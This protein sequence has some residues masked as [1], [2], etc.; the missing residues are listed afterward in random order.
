MSKIC[1]EKEKDKFEEKFN[2]SKFN[3]DFVCQ[4]KKQKEQV[5]ICF[6]VQLWSA[7]WCANQVD[8][9]DVCRRLK[10]FKD[11]MTN[12]YEQ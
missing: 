12:N 11:A 10:R 6:A 3:V 5:E 7:V 1:K 8:H 4:K 9:E 2:R